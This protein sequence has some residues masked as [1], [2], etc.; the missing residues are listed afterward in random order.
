MSAEYWASLS[1]RILMDVLLPLQIS[2][3]GIARMVDEGMSLAKTY[4]GTVM[5]M[6]SRIAHLRVFV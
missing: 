1:V 5:Y 6:V 4:N 3:F 2:D